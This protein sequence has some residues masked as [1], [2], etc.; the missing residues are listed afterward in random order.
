M[1]AT[2]SH[3]RHAARHGL[4]DRERARGLDELD[5]TLGND[6]RATGGKERAAQ[7][8]ELAHAL[9][10]PRARLALLHGNATLARLGGEQ[11][12][13]L[14]HDRAR[15]ATVVGH[16]VGELAHP[17]VSKRE[18]ARGTPQ[19]AHAN[20]GEHDA[21]GQHGALARH[22]RRQQRRGTR[23]LDETALDK[24]ALI[25]S[26]QLNGTDLARAETSH[27]LKLP[28]PCGIAEQLDRSLATIER[29]QLAAVRGIGHH[30][31]HEHGALGGAHEGATVSV[32]RPAQLAPGLGS[33]AVDAHRKSPG[34]GELALDVK[35]LRKA[36]RQHEHV[37]A[38]AGM[39]QFAGQKLAHGAARQALVCR[40]HDAQTHV[41]PCFAIHCNNPTAPSGQKATRPLG[42][43]SGRSPPRGGMVTHER[44]R[45][46]KRSKELR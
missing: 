40:A 35:R 43:R 4:V 28:A 6:A 38:S 42:V 12:R 9:H 29:I 26:Q 41:P 20:G 16:H 21:S 18:L 39:L 34:R 8:R 30:E 44:R 31:R 22:G 24:L 23:R 15:G 1:G 36:W 14:A 32:E 33:G 27:G 10:R 37:A 17:G 46:S 11:C 45:K 13:A 5:R 2:A 19:L 25:G 7:V 3:A